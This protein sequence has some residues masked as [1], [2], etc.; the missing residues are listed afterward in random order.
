MNTKE[1]IRL[2]LRF[3]RASKGI[4]SIDVR[5][6]VMLNV[7]ELFKSYKIDNIQTMERL[8]KE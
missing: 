8:I 7:R 1:V 3:S 6:N 5:K 4:S 2:Y